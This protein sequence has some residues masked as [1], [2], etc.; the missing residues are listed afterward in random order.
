MKNAQVVG[1]FESKATLA[2][3]IGLKLCRFNARVPRQCHV[4]L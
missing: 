1:L 4:S 2:R 3:R